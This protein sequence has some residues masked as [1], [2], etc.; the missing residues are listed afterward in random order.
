M[1]SDLGQSI[2]VENASGAG[3]TIGVK[4]VVGAKPDGYTVLL[5]S[6]AGLV[7]SPAGLIPNAGYDPLSDLMPVGKVAHVYY[8]LTTNKDFP[9]SSTG[10][11]IQQVKANPGK[12]NYAT[13][14]AGSQ[15]YMAVLKQKYDLNIEEIPF[16]CSPA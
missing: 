16:D 11:I 13:A 9:A 1:A 7:S 15:I 8:V 6:N 4:R 3:S 10:E 5:S 12:Y 14:N 2:I